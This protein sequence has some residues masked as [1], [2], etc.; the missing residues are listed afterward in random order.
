MPEILWRY[1]FDKEALEIWLR[2]TSQDYTRREYPEIAFAALGA[3]VSGYLGIRPDAANKTIHTR[4][5]VEDDGFAE[6]NYLPLWGGYINL[7][8]QD[9]TVFALDNLS[10][11]DLTWICDFDGIK[12]TQAVRAGESLEIKR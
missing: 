6:I 10:C 7:R 9:K 5:A 12:K 8:Y 1:G 11:S 3:V 4:S 2:M